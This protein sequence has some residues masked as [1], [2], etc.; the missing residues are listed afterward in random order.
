MGWLANAF[1]LAGMY[2]IGEKNRHGFLC[3]IAGETI[4]TFRAWQSGMIDL[5]LI[6]GIFCC[7]ALYNW[8]K[9]GRT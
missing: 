5:A 3:S 6:C 2:L 9:W 8:Q 1:I 4:W 7:V